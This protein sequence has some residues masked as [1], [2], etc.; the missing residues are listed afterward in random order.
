MIDSDQG[1]ISCIWAMKTTPKF[2]YC[3]FR[4]GFEDEKWIHVLKKMTR[5]EWKL[6]IYGNQF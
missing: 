1:H 2:D 5:I 3:L 4:S 6:R